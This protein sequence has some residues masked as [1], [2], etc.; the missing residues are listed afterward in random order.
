[1]K[2]KDKKII[3]SI[4][5]LIVFQSGMYLLAKLS[6]FEVHIL[7]STIDNK[8]PFISH[9][10]YFYISWYFMLVLMPYMFYKKDYNCF[11]NY[12]LCSNISIIVTFFIYFFYPTSILRNSISLNGLSGF[13][14]KII[15]LIDTPVLNCFPSMHCLLC[16]LYIFNIIICCNMSRLCKFGVIIWSFLVIISTLF[17][18]QH[19]ILDVISAF[20]LA[21]IIFIIVRMINKLDNKKVK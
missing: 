13:I 19:V 1:M 6:P 11:K 21:I 2:K 4:I 7:K 3:N 12:I 8:I 15:Y 18:K 14:T 9:F 20:I 16:F 17:V 10:I 5:A